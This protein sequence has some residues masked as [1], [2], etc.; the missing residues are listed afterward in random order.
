MN[1]LTREQ[2][3][4]ALTMLGVVRDI[5]RECRDIE[6][7]ELTELEWTSEDGE[8]HEEA[9]EQKEEIMDELDKALCSIED[10]ASHIF[11]ITDEE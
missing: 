7:D 1:E 9:V 11:D 10:A 5:I 2:L 4:E 6:E 8:N 3:K